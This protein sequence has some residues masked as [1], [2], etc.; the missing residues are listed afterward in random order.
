M[1]AVKAPAA[2]SD[3]VALFVAS[4]TDRAL[5]LTAPDG[6]V[7]YWNDAAERLFRAART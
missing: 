2:T 1:E 7:T 3:D 5:L 6:A 4:V